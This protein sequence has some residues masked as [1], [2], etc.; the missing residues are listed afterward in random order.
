MA[1]KPQVLLAEILIRDDLDHGDA[2]EFVDNIQLS[3]LYSYS[4]RP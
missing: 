1:L 2:A 4:Q 3:I